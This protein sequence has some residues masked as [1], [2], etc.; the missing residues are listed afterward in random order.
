MKNDCPKC[1][2]TDC[3]N[4]GEKQYNGLCRS[5]WNGVLAELDAEERAYDARLERDAGEFEYE[6]A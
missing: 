5:C 2:R 1:R 4:D 3:E 6:G